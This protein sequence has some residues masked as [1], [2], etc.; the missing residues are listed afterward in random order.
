MQ[1][2]MNLQV[3]LDI[4]SANGTAL[5]VP[6]VASAQE[7]DLQFELKLRARSGNAAS[8][9]AQ[10]GTLHVVPGHPTRVSS[11][12]VSQPPGGECEVGLVLR[13]GMA[14]LGRYKLDCSG[15]K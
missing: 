6:Y 3:W 15:R 5:V 9:L 7:A 12:T 2:D 4:Q 8:S 11:L 1:A 13:Q 10:A 14:V